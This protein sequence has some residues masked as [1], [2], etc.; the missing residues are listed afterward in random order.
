MFPKYNAFSSPLFAVQ[1]FEQ[2]VKIVLV[3]SELFLSFTASGFCVVG[4][5]L[6]KGYSLP[7]CL[8]F[9]YCVSS[10]KHLLCVYIYLSTFLIYSHAGINVEK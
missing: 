1:C 10:N 3:V 4:R 2:R 6:V 8:A 7:R 5:N 9:I